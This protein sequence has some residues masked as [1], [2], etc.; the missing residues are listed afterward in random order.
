MIRRDQE[1]KEAVVQKREQLNTTMSHIQMFE[2]NLEENKSHKK[3][4]KI[5]AD[6]KVFKDP[7]WINNESQLTVKTY[8]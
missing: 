8:R 4:E 3:K 5:S 7:R 6:I 1:I 2:K